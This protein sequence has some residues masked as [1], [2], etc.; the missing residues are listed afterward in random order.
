MTPEEYREW[1]LAQLAPLTPQLVSLADAL[2]LLMCS[3][4]ASSINLP[5]FD[6]SAMDG[7]AVRV[8]EVAAASE[9]SPLTLPVVAQNGAAGGWPAPLEVGR[10]AK[11]MT[12]APIPAGADA[13]V[14]YEWTDSGAEQVE[15]RQA[16]TVGQHVRY[17]AEDV[18]VG[19]QVVARGTVLTARH[20]ALLASVGVAHV[21]VQPRPRVLVVSTGSELREPGTELAPGMIYDSNSIMLA[22]LLSELGAIPTRVGFVADDP[23][24]FLTALGQQ[25]KDV[26]LVVTSGG[27]SM[28]DF[29]VVKAALRSRGVTFTRVDMQPGK[30]QGFGFVDDVPI[31]TLPGNPVSSF[32][33][34]EVFVRPVV[35]CL[36][37]LPPELRAPRL[38]R[39]AKQISSPMGKV[40]YL[41]ARLVQRDGEW[42]ATQVGGPGSHLLARLAE[43]NALLIVP[44][45]TATLTAGD[46]VPVLAIDEEHA[47]VS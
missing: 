18:T 31:L 13:V 38:A 3:D 9:T 4:V 8:G 14:P 12:G 22:S 5:S 39:L 1:V 25:L 45:E 15:I 10:A 42:W 41:R 7:Y 16:P 32:V 6:N 43:S 2:G 20:L 11:V 35:R 30:P 28:G 27:V 23:D 37:G 40:Q 24:E 47:W 34:F 36:L 33:S 44:A 26:D 21:T 46:L 19:D 17:T 29:D